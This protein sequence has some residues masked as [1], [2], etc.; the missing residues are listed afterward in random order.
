[1]VVDVHRGVEEYRIS[2]FRIDIAAIL[3]E[4]TSLESLSIRKSQGIK[5]KAEGMIVLV[6][7]LQYNTTLKTLRLCHITGRLQLTDNEDK[8]MASLLK[9][10]YA[11][12]KLPEIDL[13]D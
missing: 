4:N 6:T 7:A 9:N 1:L 3:Q 11:L 10:N 2:A 12:E 8:Q 5:I 13:E